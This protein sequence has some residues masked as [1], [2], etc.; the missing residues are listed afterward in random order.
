MKIVVMSDSHGCNEELEYVLNKEKDAD[1]FLHCGDICVDSYVYPKVITVKGNNDL[2][3]YPIERI[4]NLPGHRIMML[5]SHTVSYF[6]KEE[7]LLA[8][9]KENNCDIVCYGHTH[10]P[11]NIRK[12]G[13]IILN[14]GSLYHNRDGSNISYAIIRC[15]EGDASAKLKYIDEVF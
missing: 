11:V 3:N 4:I 7:I 2:Y 9:A 6:N 5:H 10:I 12:D 14:P 15:K 13:I 1:L 8:R